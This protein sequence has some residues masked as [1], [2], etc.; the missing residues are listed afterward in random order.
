MSNVS[1]SV[2][3][4]RPPDPIPELLASVKSIQAHVSTYE[5]KF[6][7]LTKKVTASVQACMADT[8]EANAWESVFGAPKLSVTGNSLTSPHSNRGD[9]EH[10][11]GSRSRIWGRTPVKTLKLTS[12]E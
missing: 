6:E 3:P 5:A 10:N 11:K 2:A 1:E 4:P 7:E 12:A 9:N 8:R